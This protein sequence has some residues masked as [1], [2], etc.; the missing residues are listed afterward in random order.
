MGLNLDQPRVLLS[1]VGL[2]MDVDYATPNLMRAYAEET[3]I[4]KVTCPRPLLLPLL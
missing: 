2:T 1:E 4:R 3:S